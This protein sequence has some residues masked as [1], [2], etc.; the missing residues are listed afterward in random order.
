[1]AQLSEAKVNEANETLEKK[2]M[3]PWK[4]N[5]PAYPTPI[6][7]LHLLPGHVCLDSIGG[8]ICWCNPVVKT[9]GRISL[10]CHREGAVCPDNLTGYNYKLEHNPELEPEL[11]HK[12][13]HIAL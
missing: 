6:H 9:Y 13:K 8:V 4:I 11:E 1:M 10:V 5:R 2:Q 7:N 3:K 12:E